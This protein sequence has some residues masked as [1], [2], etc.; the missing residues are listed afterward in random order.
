MRETSVSST[1]CLSFLP[2]SSLSYLSHFLPTS[3]FLTPSILPLS[4]LAVVLTGLLLF[5][6]QQFAGINA[7]I[8]FSST[9]F[10][11]VGIDSDVA[12]S[13]LVGLANVLGE[14]C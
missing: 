10:R 2:L 1:P 11:Q 3:F 13:A 4:L 9:V 14:H 7:I 12:A 5:A 8:Y 6:F